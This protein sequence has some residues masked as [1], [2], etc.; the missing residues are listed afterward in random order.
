MNSFFNPINPYYNEN[1]NLSNEKVYYESS[2]NY[3]ER[4]ERERAKRYVSPSNAINPKLIKPKNKKYLKNHY[5]NNH[6]DLQENVQRLS[7]SR[8][9]IP[10]QTPKIIKNINK[11]KRG[12][13]Q[14][15]DNK[16]STQ[17]LSRELY[18]PTPQLSIFHTPQGVVNMRSESER[19]LSSLRKMFNS[20]KKK[21][22]NKQP[23][24]LR[25]QKLDF[26]SEKSN[27]P[28]FNYNFRKPQ[29]QKIKR[30][31]LNVNNANNV[32]NPIKKKKKNNN[33]NDEV[34]TQKNNNNN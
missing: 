32:N 6:H 20:S 29:Q 1:Y 10:V 22:P 8:G 14:F 2:P 31:I 9:L 4:M 15:F 27:N 5:N 28:L 30:S 12:P 21:T 18:P 7:K 26:F 11:R 19:Y 16:K 23:P 25:K 24:E 13:V 33:N 17:I 3:Y 34:P